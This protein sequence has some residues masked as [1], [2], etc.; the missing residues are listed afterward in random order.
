MKIVLA[1]ASPRRKR[2]LKGIVRKFT[3]KIARIAEGIH[4]GESFSHA[5]MRLAEM[6]AKKVAAK[7]ADAI[8]IGADTIAYFGKRNF[9]KTE[10]EDAAR[11]AL[12]FLS[13]KTHFVITGVAVLFPDGRRVKY[14]ERAS[15]RMRKLDAR[16]IEAY[17]RCG[18]W[19]GRAGSYDVSG[20]G[21]EL[22]ANVRGEEET[23][24]GLP[25]KRLRSV[26]SSY[27]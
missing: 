20:I 16:E 17:L 22:V 5:A 18:E 27:L 14:Y 24:V 4:S 10:S 7:N 26:L 9:R 21:R 6:K 2:L 1:S 12:S 25:L 11:M 13:G 15:V 19:R 23:V 3:V 8:V